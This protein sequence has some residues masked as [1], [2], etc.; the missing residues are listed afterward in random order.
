METKKRRHFPET[1]KRQAVAR[2]LGSGLPIAR[3]AEEL[4][5]H[6]TL[7]RRWVKQFSEPGPARP[8]AMQVPSPADLAAENSRLKREI[9]RAQME[10]EIQKTPRSSSERPAGGAP[11]RR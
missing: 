9:S 1:F 10:R 6:E 4:D 11:V 5:L 7:P 2:V 3:V 8:P